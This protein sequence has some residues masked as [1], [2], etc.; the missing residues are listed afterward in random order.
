MNMSLCMPP[1]SGTFWQG[2]GQKRTS[3]EHQ[4]Y[5]EAPEALSL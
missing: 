2:T 3:E 5:V 1:S 4:L